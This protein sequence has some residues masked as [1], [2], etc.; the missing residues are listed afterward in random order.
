[1]ERALLFWRGDLEKKDP[2]VYAKA[3]YAKICTYPCE[4]KAFCGKCD[5][6][7]SAWEA[8][9][10]K[11]I[12]VDSTG[13]IQSKG[14]DITKAVL[15][16]QMFRGALFSINL[17]HYME[18]QEC[19]RYLKDVGSSIL[20]LKRF[21][22]AVCEGSSQVAEKCEQLKPIVFHNTRFPGKV[23]YPIVVHVKGFG[24]ILYAQIPP[25]FWAIPAPSCE[26][27]LTL[28]DFVSVVEEIAKRCSQEE[29][30]FFKNEDA[31]KWK[32]VISPHMP[33]LIFPLFQS[34]C[35]VQL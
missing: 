13:T 25:F 16:V 21:H 1:M 2:A 34:N 6:S 27:E 18:C 5:N 30:E 4:R 29:T 33:V 7:T 9:F 35:C 32:K 26:R 3:V 24:I 8:A 31:R 19:G 23:L 12:K 14:K 17:E 22:E 28:L 10:S 11:E 15:L 20:E